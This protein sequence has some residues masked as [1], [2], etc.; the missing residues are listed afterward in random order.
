VTTEP[1]PTSSVPSAFSSITVARAAALELC[2]PASGSAVRSWR[3][4]LR[5]PEMSP[6]TGLLIRAATSRRFVVEGA[7]FPLSLLEGPPG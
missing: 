4:R 2:D 3:R 6:N 7:R 5:V 1:K